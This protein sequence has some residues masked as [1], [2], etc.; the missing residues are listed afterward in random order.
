[1]VVCH[2]MNN[3]EIQFVLFN[4]SLVSYENLYKISFRELIWSRMEKLNRNFDI[5]SFRFLRVK[6]CYLHD[7]VALIHM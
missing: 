7:I 5:L 3:D 4:D 6:Q 1:M 2:T